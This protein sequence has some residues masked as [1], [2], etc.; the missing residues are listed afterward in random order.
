MDTRGGA[1]RAGRRSSLIVLRART[2]QLASVAFFALATLVSIAVLAPASVV[3]AIVHALSEGRL[4][5]AGTS[6]RLWN[7]RGV[8]IAAASGSRVLVSWSVTPRHLHASRLVGEITFGAARP[9]RF[10][11]A[12]DALRL[13]AADVTLPAALIAEA[14]GPYGGYRIGG[15]LRLRSEQAILRRQSASARMT[16]DWTDATTGLI[17]VAPLGSYVCEIDWIASHGEIRVRST[18]G[19]LFVD[20]AGRWSGSAATLSLDAR[21]SGKGSDTIDAWLRTMAPELPGRRFRFSWP[22]PA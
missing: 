6:G 11:A 3:A 12:P 4:T 19:P 17:D 1:V 21:T 7:G 16:I 2:W 20:G 22:A 9:W 14:L 5:L 8:L 18:Q 13:D 15:M 10:I